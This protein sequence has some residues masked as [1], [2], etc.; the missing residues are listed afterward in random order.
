MHVKTSHGSAL[1]LV[2]KS[3][4]EHTFETRD[5]LALQW[6]QQAPTKCSTAAFIFDDHP[7]VHGVIVFCTTCKSAHTCMNLAEREGSHRATRHACGLGAAL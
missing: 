7:D 5:K 4:I 6:V 1:C 3:L 2:I